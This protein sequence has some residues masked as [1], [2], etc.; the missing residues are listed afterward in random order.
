M[1]IDFKFKLRFYF[2]PSQ[3]LVD[4]ITKGSDCI[5]GE[6]DGRTTRHCYR[7]SNGHV[8]EHSESHWGPCT[9]AKLK[10]LS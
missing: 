4:G 10:R 1:K 9:F 5:S 7:L 2:G 3:D 8:W 6:S